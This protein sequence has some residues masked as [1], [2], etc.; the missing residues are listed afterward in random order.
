MKKLSPLGQ[1]GIGHIEVIV[2]AIVLALIGLAG[3]WVISNQN[4]DTADGGKSLQSI[5]KNAKCDYADKDLCKFFTGWKE[6]KHYTITA[7][8]TDE[9]GE[10]FDMTIRAEGDSKTHMQMGGKLNYEVI[11]INNATYTKAGNTWWKQSSQ[12]QNSTNDFSKETVDNYKLKEP[13]KEEVEARYKKVGKEAC[14]NLTCFKYEFIDDE[15]ADSKQYIWFDTKDYLLRRMQSTSHD[16][17]FDASFSYDKFSISVPSPVK[18]L[19]PDQFLVPGQA[20]PTTMPSTPSQ[21]DLDEL[22]RQYR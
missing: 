7:K 15:D 20:E 13:T 18:E 6:Q 12:S 2:I 22:M 1:R 17:T 21:A 4:K 19:G 5:I 16:N 9:E 14:G 3:W 8:Q 11:S 10:A